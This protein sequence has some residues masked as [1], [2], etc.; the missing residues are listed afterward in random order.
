MKTLN[1]SRTFESKSRFVGIGNFVHM[2][3]IMELPKWRFSRTGHFG[4]MYEKL[5]IFG[6]NQFASVLATF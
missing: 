1:E 6:K 3:K 5:P 2:I 4:P